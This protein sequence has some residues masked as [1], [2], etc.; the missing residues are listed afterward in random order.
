MTVRRREDVDDVRV[1]KLAEE[2]GPVTQ[3][4][5]GRPHVPHGA[6]GRR[7]RGGVGLIGTSHARMSGSSSHASIDGPPATACPPRIATDGAT[8]AIFSGRSM[9]GVVTDFSK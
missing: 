8:R 9:D 3:L 6:A 1:T 4:R 5:E 2:Q 7:R